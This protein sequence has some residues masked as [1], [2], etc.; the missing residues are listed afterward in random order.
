MIYYIFGGNNP[1]LYTHVK[2]ALYFSDSLQD[3]I[4][5]FNAINKNHK[6]SHTYLIC[7][8]ETNKGS[9]FKPDKIV[10][11]Q[12]R[13]PFLVIGEYHVNS[14]ASTP[15]ETIRSDTI[16]L[17]SKGFNHQFNN[18]AK[19]ICQFENN[20][21]NH[22]DTEMRLRY[23]YTNEKMQECCNDSYLVS[24]EEVIEKMEKHLGL[25][26]IIL[27]ELIIDNA[28]TAS[29]FIKDDDTGKVIGVEKINTD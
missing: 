24:T 28:N 26:K 10:L 9:F 29:R 22:V 19:A 16:V 25:G 1:I 12:E 2:E 8:F 3:S 27:D 11:G 20:L 6:Y 4:E 15:T 21:A 14:D 17:K 13:T 5:R 18:N 23:K 7:D